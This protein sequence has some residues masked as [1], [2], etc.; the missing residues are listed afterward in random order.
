[1]S[2]ATLASTAPSFDVESRDRFRASL[3]LEPARPLAPTLALGV[4]MVLLVVVIGIAGFARF[5]A[6]VPVAGVVAWREVA[7]PV[8]SEIAGIVTRAHVH[9]GETVRAG[10]PLFSVRRRRPDVDGVGA[11][12]Q[13]DIAA[14]ARRDRLDAELAALSRQRARLAQEAATRDALDDTRLR[15]LSRQDDLLREKL[16]I[17]ERMLERYRQAQDRGLVSALDVDRV[18]LDLTGWRAERLGVEQQRR[19]IAAEQSGARTQAVQNETALD[20]QASSL[21]AQRAEVDRWIAE[22]FDEVVVVAD[23]AGLVLDD[24][25]REGQGVQAGEALARVLPQPN[26]PL[27]EAWVGAEDA[28]LLAPGMTGVLRRVERAGRERLPDRYVIVA[29]APSPRLTTVAAAAGEPARE[30]AE[31]RVLI[32]ADETDTRAPRLDALR[33]GTEIAMAFQARRRSLLDLL[34]PS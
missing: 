18:A 19:A 7:T 16:T 11:D 15:D 6:M 33:A 23:R 2:A 34:S 24:L 1:M 17:G 8:S 20:A 29:I 28:A 32:R 14:R 25:A 31:Y 22:N 3:P 9:A 5:P 27:I 30:R 21:R 4:T 10:Q 26:A 13:G 12:A